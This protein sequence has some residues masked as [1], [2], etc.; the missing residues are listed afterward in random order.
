VL[1]KVFGAMRDEAT[2]GWRKVGNEE[3]HGLYWS[4]DVIGM[5][6][7]RMRWTVDKPWRTECGVNPSQDRNRLRAVVN[8]VMNLRVPKIRGIS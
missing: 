4:P 3:L 2:G 6:S 1:R 7:R 5:M 8:A